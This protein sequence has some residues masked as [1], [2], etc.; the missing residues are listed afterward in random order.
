MKRQDGLYTLMLRSFHQGKKVEHTEIISVF[1]KIIDPYE[2]WM[3]F[4]A[5]SEN[6]ELEFVV[7]NTTEAGLKYQPIPLKKESRWNLFQES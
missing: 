2:E 5:L 3:G 4:L 1:S 7:S 6:P